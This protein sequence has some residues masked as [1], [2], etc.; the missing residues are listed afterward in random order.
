MDKG[1]ADCGFGIVH[2]PRAGQLRARGVHV[3][4]GHPLEL[5]REARLAA[6]S[7]AG[8]APTEIYYCREM[9]EGSC[10]AKRRR[11]VRVLGWHCVNNVLKNTTG[12]ISNARTC[13][14]GREHIPPRLTLRRCLD[15]AANSCWPQRTPTIFLRT[16]TMSRS[17]DR[18]RYHR[19]PTVRLSVQT[20]SASARF[21]G[22]TR[23]VAF[24]RYTVP[25][26]PQ[27]AAAINLDRAMKTAT[28]P[29]LPLRA[30]GKNTKDE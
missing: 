20:F 21:R 18:V 19:T 27:L 6:V 17:R 9:N 24:T 16:L 11:S 5:R 13:S 28:P 8:R 7:A 2:R 26:R 10:E 25:E 22:K 15:Y 23:D 1:S 30:A 29:P 14:N 4:Q 3:R 12:R